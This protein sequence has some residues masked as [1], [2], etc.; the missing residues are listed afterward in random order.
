MAASPARL[1][2]AAKHLLRMEERRRRE[3]AEGVP[4]HRRLSPSEL[5]ECT[6]DPADSL[7]T[8]LLL[9]REFLS[10]HPDLPESIADR[11]IRK[12]R[13]GGASC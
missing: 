6:A 9:N 10:E 12:A 1:L 7:I 13:R 8:S 3:I 11:A 4:L 5:V 2:A